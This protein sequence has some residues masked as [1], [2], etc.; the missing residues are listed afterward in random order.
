MMTLDGINLSSSHAAKQRARNTG[1][2]G[3]LG[4]SMLTAEIAAEA[5][6]DS[7]CSIGSS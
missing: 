3:L 2:S 7:G 1:P 5:M 6:G 4:V